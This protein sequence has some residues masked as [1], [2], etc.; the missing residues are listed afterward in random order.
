MGQIRRVAGRK[1]SRHVAAYCRAILSLP[2]GGGV[3]GESSVKRAADTWREVKGICGRSLLLPYPRQN[4][5]FFIAWVYFKM[6]N[7]NIPYN[8]KQESIKRALI[9]YTVYI[10]IP[11]YSKTRTLFAYVTYLPL[12]TIQF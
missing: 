9:V 11:L 5:Y 4:A 2:K 3:W 12:L 1:I 8:I 6:L 7:L 10:I